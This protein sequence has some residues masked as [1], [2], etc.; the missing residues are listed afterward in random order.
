ML[1]VALTHRFGPKGFAL[2]AAF[3]SPTPGVTVVF[4]PSGCGKS[5]LL[6]AVAGLLRPQSG[7]VELD[8]TLLLDTATRLIVPP[9]KRR[10]GVVFQDARLFPHLSVETNLR[11]GLRRAPRGA[12]G[13]GFEE[14]VA[15]LGIAHLLHRRPAALSGGERQRVALGRALLS[16]PHILLM[17]EP[18][19]ALDAP[20]RAEV[21]PFLAR[22]RERFRLP[23]LYVT[24]ALD[25]VDQLADHLVLMEAGRVQAAGPLEDLSTRTD[26]P[27]L[28]ARRDGGAV[29]SCTLL[30]HDPARGLSR[31][32]FAGG[33]LRVPLREEAIGT[34]LRMRVRA[35]D[36]SV[37]ITEPKGL[38]VQ[39]ILPATLESIGPA[40]PH[41]AMLRLRLGNAILLSRVTADAVARL[42]LHPGQPLW[43]LVK[44]AAFSPAASAESAP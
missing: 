42:E 30:D 18:L 16:R 34:A 12:E 39:N 37:A 6:V 9:E 11:Y 23:I 35:R 43:A 21:L 28:T 44:S 22:V 33:D 7:R 25:E 29:L 2:D 10:C 8:G 5:T 13:P 38:S 3:T 4:G 19:A 27:L 14:V 36:V 15:L 20:R 1:D 26:L 41:E 32:G 40:A 24:H 31:L 17:D